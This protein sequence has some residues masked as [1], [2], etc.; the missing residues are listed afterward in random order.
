[1]QRV[2][3]GATCRPNSAQQKLRCGRAHVA[4]TK[5]D[6]REYVKNPTLTR[7]EKKRNKVR[8]NRNPT[9]LRA[10]PNPSSRPSPVRTR[11]KPIRR[12]GRG[13]DTGQG[14]RTL[15]GPGLD[16]SRGSRAE[17]DKR[18]PHVPRRR[19]IGRRRRRRGSVAAA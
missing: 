6:A 3:F 18:L 14:G 8:G 15:G 12:L 5:K 4:P 11:T 16:A 7:G 17:G 19:G 9:P 13:G 2:K 1:M 10:R